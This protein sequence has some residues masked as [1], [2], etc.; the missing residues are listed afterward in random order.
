[1]IRMV[2]MR[3]DAIRAKLERYVYDGTEAL[4]AIRFV[5]NS[6]DRP[7]DVM[8][9]ISKILQRQYRDCVHIDTVINFLD[10]DE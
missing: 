10:G 5:L 2:T 1:M 3:E 7:S 4:E 6:P 8:K 9:A